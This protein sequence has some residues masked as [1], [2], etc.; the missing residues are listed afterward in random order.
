MA[1]FGKN[2]ALG[3]K[4]GGLQSSGYMFDNSYISEQPERTNAETERFY[5]ILRLRT[6]TKR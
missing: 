2:R 3:R 6:K 4:E 1:D 5:E